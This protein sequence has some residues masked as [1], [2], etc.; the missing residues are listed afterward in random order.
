MLRAH[1]LRCAALI[2]GYARTAEAQAL[3]R[4][5]AGRTIWWRPGRWCACAP[6][7]V[8][9]DDGGYAGR[10]ATP[11]RGP[12]AAVGGA[13]DRQG[14]LERGA[15]VLVQVPRRGYVPSV[16]CARCRTIAR[17]RHCMGRCALR[18]GRR[19]RGLPLGAGASTPPCG[20]AAAAPTRSRAVVIGAR[21]TA[22]ELGRGSR[23]RRHHLRRETPWHAEIPPGPLLVVATRARRT[24]AP[25]GYG[26]ALLLDTWALLGRQDLQAAEDTLRRWLAAAALVHPRADGGWSR[27]SPRRRFP[28]CRR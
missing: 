15:P 26:A 2:G 12:P 21:R 22:E 10:T 28:P 20:A 5:A 24:P 1:Q 16:A 27:S 6:R 17:C 23:H 3:V 19:R 9:L 7:V 8:A 18:A 25:D 11:R 4:A 13:A 14:A